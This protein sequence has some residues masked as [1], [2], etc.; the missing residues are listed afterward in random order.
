M[1]SLGKTVELPTWKGI[2]PIDELICLELRWR[3]WNGRP[4][5]LNNSLWKGL[6][7]PS[8]WLRMAYV[9]GIELV[10]RPLLI[11]N[12]IWLTDLAIGY[13]SGSSGFNLIH[14]VFNISDFSLIPFPTPFSASH[15]G[16]SLNADVSYLWACMGFYFLAGRFL[17]NFSKQDRKGYPSPYNVLLSHGFPHG[18]S[19]AWVLLAAGGGC[20]QKPLTLLGRAATL[21]PCLCVILSQAVLSPL[22]MGGWEKEAIATVCLDLVSSCQTHHVFMF[23]ESLFEK[24]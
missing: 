2:W 10:A 11:W 3:L 20:C 13:F 5:C 12:L 21:C 14:S 23:S 18:L 24:L 15:W 9:G 22:V 8:G 16:E 7:I 19:P 4:L 1:N 6:C 17:L